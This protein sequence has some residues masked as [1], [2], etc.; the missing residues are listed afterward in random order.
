[1]LLPLDLP[2]F[3]DVDLDYMTNRVNLL[4]HKDFA[5][6]RQSIDFHINY[7]VKYSFERCILWEYQM[8]FENL[9]LHR[10]FSNIN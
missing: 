8:V 4:T 2:L 3:H 5:D 7:F 1:M 6:D 10:L 9:N